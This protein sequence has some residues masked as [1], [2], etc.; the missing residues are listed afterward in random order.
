M[1]DHL[2]SW[3]LKHHK[4]NWAERGGLTLSGAVHLSH[5]EFSVLLPSH[6]CPKSRIAS[7]Y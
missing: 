7:E 5:R 4:E 1:K 3:E 2:F 6:L